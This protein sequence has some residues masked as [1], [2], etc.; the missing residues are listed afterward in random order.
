MLRVLAAT[1]NF[2]STTLQHIYHYDGLPL[3][4]KDFHTRY[5]SKKHFK[6]RMRSMNAHQNYVTSTVVQTNFKIVWTTMVMP[7]KT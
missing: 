3:V 2:F 1:Q 4:S 7:P 6:L 5:V